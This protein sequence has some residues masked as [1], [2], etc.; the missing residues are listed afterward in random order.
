MD[1]GGMG[2]GDGRWDM[3]DSARSYMEYHLANESGG[4]SKQRSSS[5]HSNPLVAVVFWGCYI[6]STLLLA[7]T[8]IV[9]FLALILALPITAAAALIILIVITAIES[10]L[11]R[12]KA[13]AEPEKKDSP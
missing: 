12:K 8:G 2:G 11:R 3:K 10:L 9:F 13:L 5:K 7:S 4:F 1:F 6:I